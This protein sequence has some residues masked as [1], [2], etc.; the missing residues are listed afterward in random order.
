MRIKL[1]NVFGK[2]LFLMMILLF[3]LCYVVFLYK[4]FCVSVWDYM[5]LLF[6]FLCL[7]LIEYFIRVGLVDYVNYGNRFFNFNSF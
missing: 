4:M 3:S 1:V 2:S 6:C 5:G 7:D